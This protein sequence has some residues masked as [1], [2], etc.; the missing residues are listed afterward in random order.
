M[1]ENDLEQRVLGTYDRSHQRGQERWG[2]W[3]VSG[4]DVGVVSAIE[5]LFEEV[6]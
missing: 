2:P 3:D 1:L 4:V 5:G 6:T